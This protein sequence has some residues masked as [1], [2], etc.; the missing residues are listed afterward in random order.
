MRRILVQFDYTPDFAMI[1]ISCH[2]RDYRMCWLLNNVLGSAL[3]RDEDF[4]I[5]GKRGITRKF[6]MFSC[7]V[8]EDHVSYHLLANRST[9]GFLMPELKNLDYLF[10]VRG[11]YREEDVD[12][13]EQ[14]IRKAINV[15]S[16]FRI[17]PAEIKSAENLIFE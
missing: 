6:P 5:H 10:L 4:E 17:D 11:P 13:L 12:E 3:V 1:G 7:Q 15:S 16:A 2:Q 8:E 14:R 9:D